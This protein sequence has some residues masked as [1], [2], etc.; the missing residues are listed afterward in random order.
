MPLLFNVVGSGNVLFLIPRI[1]FVFSRV[2]SF[3]WFKAGWL[4]VIYLFMAQIDMAW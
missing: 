1:D 4:V 3:M 2:A